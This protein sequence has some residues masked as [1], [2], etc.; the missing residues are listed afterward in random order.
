VT[1]GKTDTCRKDVRAPRSPRD[2][3]ARGAAPSFE[4][5][6]DRS[7]GALIVV[8]NG[9]RRD[10]FSS[11][12]DNSGLRLAATDDPRTARALFRSAPETF[13]LMLIDTQLPGA[14]GIALVQAL[15]ETRARVPV[16]LLSDESPDQ[17]ATK[18][19]VAR[20][21]AETVVLPPSVTPQRLTAIVRE[22]LRSARR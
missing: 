21:D 8:G 15:R 17:V 22:L 18:L 19:P 20:G 6:G 10:A 9:A 13:G 3:G 16:V 2:P 14:D 11:W 4:L 1:Q 12:L 5:P 7:I